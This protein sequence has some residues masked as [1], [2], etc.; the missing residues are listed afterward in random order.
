MA[1]TNL[2]EMMIIKEAGPGFFSE[3]KQY[4]DSGEFTDEFYDL[5]AFV[6]K[7]KKVMKH[8]KWLDYMKATDRNSTDSETE[9]PAREAIKAIVDLEDALQA[10]DREFDR[11]NKGDPQV[12][13]RA[14]IE[15]GE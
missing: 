4:G 5:F 8:P 11:M 7:M 15:S 9:A 6:T 13:R 12:D 10:I 3:A 2:K 1:L 14:A